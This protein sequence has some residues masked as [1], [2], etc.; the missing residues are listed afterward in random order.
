[1]TLLLLCGCGKAN[2]PT[3][4][5]EKSAE[6]TT[7]PRDSDR[8][9]APASD[10]INI[11][12]PPPRDGVLA[13]LNQNDG[14]AFASLTGHSDFSSSGGMW[15]SK[16]ETPDPQD[17]T[18]LKTLM[19]KEMDSL[20]PCDLGLLFPSEVEFRLDISGRAISIALPKGQ[21]VPCL[22]DWLKGL[23]LGAPQG[24]KPVQVKVLLSVA[25]E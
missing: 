22:S 24:G 10:Y 3:P 8:P 23:D 7:A 5:A 14:G 17:A 2:E 16:V 12:K 20:Q 13:L 18:R 6:Q 19:D 9:R 25:R 11:K 21:Q 15:V 1:V 4:N